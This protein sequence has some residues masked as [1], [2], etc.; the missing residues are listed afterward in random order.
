MIEQIKMY[1][2]LKKPI[3]T[4]KCSVL[5]ETEKKVL[6][7][8]AD[9]ANKEQICRAAKMLFDVDGYPKFETH[10]V[11][12]NTNKRSHIAYFCGY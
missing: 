2:V 12:S 10:K 1:E 5:R 6:V 3:F 8:V 11:D 7:E 9:W 4:E